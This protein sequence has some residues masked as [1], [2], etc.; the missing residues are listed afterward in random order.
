ML[1]SMNSF[2]RKVRLNKNLN[3]STEK[4]FFKTCHL[5]NSFDLSFNKSMRSIIFFNT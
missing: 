1:K 5:I 2:V 4:E 3:L